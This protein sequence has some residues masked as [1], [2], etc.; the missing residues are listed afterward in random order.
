MSAENVELTR[1][2]YVQFAE[3]RPLSEANA[4]ADF[5]WDMSHFSGWPEQPEYH[6]VAGMREFLAEWSDA[7]EGWRMEQLELHDCGDKVVAV[8][9][10]HGRSK[11]T[12]MELDMPFAQ[13]WTY[14][15]GLR[16]RMEMYSEVDEALRAAGAR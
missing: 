6:G 8:M 3:G 2:G 4:T 9:R 14:R 11:L 13:V 15:D 16:S 10:Q 5:V 7:W 12:G 1:Q